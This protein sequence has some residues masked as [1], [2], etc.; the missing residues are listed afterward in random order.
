VAALLVGVVGTSLF[1]VRAESQRRR[2]DAA[3]RDAREQTQVAK[4]QR[5]TAA[6]EKARADAEAALARQRLYA[7]N[8]R[9]IDACLDAKNLRMA[10]QLYADN[11]SLVG[12]PLPLEMQCLAARLDEA[13]VVR[14]VQP[15]M[16]AD[17]EYAAD[18]RI[19]AVTAALPDDL[20]DKK[21]DTQ[22]WASQSRG[23]LHLLR[24]LPRFLAVGPR[25]DYRPAAEDDGE[26]AAAI[27]SWLAGPGIAVAGDDTPWGAQRPLASR[28]SGDRFAVQGHDGVR[29]VTGPHASE[30]TLL[31]D[32]RSRL[33]KTRFNAD[34][35]RLAGLAADGTLRLWDTSQGRLLAAYGNERGRALD[36]C[37]SPSGRRLATDVGNSTQHASSGLHMIAVHDAGDG[38]RLWEATVPAGCGIAAR[39]AFGPGDETLFCFLHDPEIRVHDA[40]SGASLAVLRGH[41]AVVESLAASPDGNHVASGAA[42]GHVRVWDARRLELQSE[43][44]GHE[45]PVVALAFSPDGRSLASGGMDGSIRIWP[46]TDPAP[47]NVLR[48]VEGLSAA[49]FSPDG[50]VMAVAPKQGGSIELWNARSV[51]RMHRLDLGAA[52]VAMIAFSPDGRLLVAACAGARA[53]GGAPIWRVG[54]GELVATVGDPG[55]AIASAR[56]SPESDR[57]LTVS[58]LGGV[59][60]WEVAGG[61]R[62]QS[63]TARVQP[64]FSRA[65]AV[66]GLGGARVGVGVGQVF[67]AATGRPLASELRPR[68][69]TAIAASSDGR[70]L[71]V[72]VPLGDVHLEEF[73]TGRHLTRLVGHAGE[74]KAVAFTAAGDRL[75]SGGA[76]G[77]ARIWDVDSHECLL[78]LRG[79]EAPIHAV[80][81]SPDGLRLVTSSAD[82]T[83]RIWDAGLGTELLSL[84][85][86]REH[87]QA[88]ALGPDGDV[89]L[90][91]DESGR[92][93]LWGLSNAAVID[94]RRRTPVVQ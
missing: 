25:L 19:L 88:V 16:V 81:F 69:T 30:R 35:S 75:A 78:V 8:L 80:I 38:S 3:L 65:G 33:A 59:A 50:R 85:G 48:G 83:V 15:N 21:P 73:A 74:V 20:S 47:L 40:A 43:H 58:V 91:A 39:L 72:G 54:S 6:R 51:E 14:D 60:A 62:L 70:L 53:A 94:A 36:F 52:P 34:A 79:H 24:R 4:E 82:G 26:H 68:P 89:I 12:G 55:E 13:L 93:S 90:T 9:S 28:P 27:R 5:E 71:A 76:D 77:T 66:F 2:A 41:T 31:D 57:L 44:M 10:R 32:S 87:P 11:V 37:F 63:F 46:A 1:A 22:R 7:A 56:F 17:L 49:A 45:A 61:N 64:V 23:P 86:Q 29:I 67:D 92:V 84:P 18:G 42:N